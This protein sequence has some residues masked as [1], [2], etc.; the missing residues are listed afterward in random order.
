MKKMRGTG[1][2]YRP[3]YVDKGTGE[4]KEA[5]TWWIEYY[6]RGVRFRE[7]SGSRSRS[8][9]ENFLKQRL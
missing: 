7:S 8:D 9:A 6:V 5:S 3:T 1:L 2:V 4:R